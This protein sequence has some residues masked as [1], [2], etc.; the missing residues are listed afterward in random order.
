MLL[1]RK[2]ILTSY[3]R[4]FVDQFFASPS[5][6]GQLLIAP[7]GT[8]SAQ[9]AIEIISRML[10]VEPSA[11]VLLLTAR[12]LM[13]QWLQRL[14][15]VLEPSQTLEGSRRKLRQLSEAAPSS[16]F[17]WPGGKIVVMDRDSIERFSDVRFS[18]LKTPWNLVI[19]DRYLPLSASR[20]IQLSALLEELKQ[21]PPDRRILVLGHDQHSASEAPGLSWLHRTVWDRSLLERSED[22][23]SRA[24]TTEATVTYQLTDAEIELRT[25]LKEFV[26]KWSI[27]S[28]TSPLDRAVALLIPVAES[29]PFALQQHLQRFRPSK[30]LLVLHQSSL[31]DEIDSAEAESRIDRLHLGAATLQNM[32][33]GLS[34]DSKVEALLKHL[35][36]HHDSYKRAVIHCRFSATVR[37]L[38][39]ALMEVNDS[40]FFMVGDL[41]AEMRLD[42]LSSFESQRGILVTT[43]AAPHVGRQFGPMG[44]KDLYVSTNS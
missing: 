26:G 18:V 21:T 19:F 16:S 25:R 29:S 37:Y 20:N 15:E 35:Q 42:V 6:R 41:S 4:D 43:A 44:S 13:L 5:E 33:D 7:V 10:S 1:E 22:W 24:P 36:D 17:A 11:R 39:S 8:G 40:C 31:F 9:S 32:L 28:P 23:I 30:A 27:P 14:D 38:E 12:M 34:V 3:Q 2:R